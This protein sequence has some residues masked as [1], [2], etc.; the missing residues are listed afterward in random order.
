MLAKMS[1]MFKKSALKPL[2]KKE[3]HSTMYKEVDKKE[4][5]KEL[6]VNKSQ[7]KS[8]VIDFEKVTSLKDEFKAD[9]YEKY[10]KLEKEYNI[11]VKE[12]QKWK[13]L[14]QRYFDE[15]K[16]IEDTYIHGKNKINISPKIIGESLIEYLRVLRLKGVISTLLILNLCFLVFLGNKVLKDEKVVIT[17]DNYTD[18]KD[19]KILPYTIQV[20]VF[21]NFDQAKVLVDKLKDAGLTAMI[22]KPFNSRSDFYRVYAGQ[23]ETVSEAENVMEKKLVKENGFKN[24][25]IRKRL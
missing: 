18:L 4:Q 2:S 7:V 14:A 10:K 16:F 5:E 3:I 8:N 22:S 23:F 6:K 17:K 15:K 25:V 9:I 24:C 11:L 21:D 13:G 1:E 20:A 19:E 12:C